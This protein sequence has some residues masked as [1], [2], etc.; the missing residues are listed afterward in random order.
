MKET[1]IDSHQAQACRQA[2]AD[3]QAASLA[4]TNGWAHVDKDQV[5]R[6][7]HELYGE[8]AA[9]MAG[10]QPGDE[11]AQQFVERHFAIASRFYTPSGPAYVGM[12]LLYAEDDA[13]R[14]FHNSFHP[15]MVRFLGAAMRAYVDARP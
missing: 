14:E 8:I 4:A 11:R 1:N 13:M 2:L 5:H 15:D 9:E 7:W 12:A 6:D 10:M 3:E